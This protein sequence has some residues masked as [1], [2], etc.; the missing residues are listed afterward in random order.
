MASP[1]RAAQIPGAAPVRPQ[2]RQPGSL[3]SDPPDFGPSS[4]KRTRLAPLVY[5]GDIVLSVP[6][7]KLDARRLDQFGKL[8]LDDLVFHIERPGDLPIRALEELFALPGIPEGL[9]VTP[10]IATS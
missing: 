5:R 8:D 1:T 3:T 2:E 10:N 7:K 6:G 4:R 9:T